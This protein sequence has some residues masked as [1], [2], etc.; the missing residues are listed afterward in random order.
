MKKE[1]LNYNDDYNGFPSI[2]DFC[3]KQT[4]FVIDDTHSVITITNENNNIVQNTSK[5]S[6]NVR[7]QENDSIFSAFKK[8]LEGEKM[9][10]NN[11]CP[12]VEIVGK[13][14]K[15]QSQLEKAENIQGKPLI[16]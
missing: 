16:S 4:K 6:N 1:K 12:E 5:N 2:F 11:I 15:T 14:S 10:N 3:C 9:G 7:E 13:K 8:K